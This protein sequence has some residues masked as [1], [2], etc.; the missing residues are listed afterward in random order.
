LIDPRGNLAYWAVNMEDT[1]SWG[2]SSREIARKMTDTWCMVVS[3]TASGRY[4]RETPEGDL[5]KPRWP[6]LEPIECLEKAFKD[7]IVDSEDHPI[8]KKLLGLE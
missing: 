6:E 7:R 1:S 2:T 5:G 3:N 8:I 4:E